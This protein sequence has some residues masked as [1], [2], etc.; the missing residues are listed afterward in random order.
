MLNDH[1]PKSQDTIE[2]YT[3][4][5]GHSH[6]SESFVHEHGTFNAFSFETPTCDQLHSPVFRSTDNRLHFRDLNNSKQSPVTVLS[7][8]TIPD[9]DVSLPR[10]NLFGPKSIMERLGRCSEFSG[11]PQENG[12]KFL[13]EFESYAILHEL[14]R[15]D[16]KRKLAA[17]HLHLKGPALT[18]FDS[19]SD[20]TRES[21]EDVCVLFKGKFV[22]FQAQGAN[23]LMHT[24]IFQSLTLTPG[25][26]VDDFYCSVLEKGQLLDK[27]P[28]E[29]MAKFIGGLPYDMA[30]FVRAGNPDDIQAALTAAK[31]AETCGYRK[32]EL[33]VNAITSTKPKYQTPPT[34]DPYT[35]EIRSLKAQV[36]SLSEIVLGKPEH[37]KTQNTYTNSELA[38]LKDEV[39][40][41]SSAVSKMQVNTQRAGHNTTNDN[42]RVYYKSSQTNQR[43][44]RTIYCYRCNG[45]SHYENEC[46]WNGYGEISQ[47][48]TCQICAQQG[49]TA[50]LCIK[51]SASS[52]GNYR[53]PGDRH[54]RPE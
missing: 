39:H 29:L 34:P 31:M 1:D 36:K 48:S 27:P 46:N 54:D 12:R 17:F 30:Y 14:D 50:D 52:S 40:T 20:E 6:L 24:E 16:Q 25:Q 21:W 22:N 28:H 33:S 13:K 26:S 37:D 8:Q 15:Y 38:E 18:W 42:K 45:A 9:I 49:H 11:Y 43:G 5:Q 4:N 44:R 23:S 2:Q 10:Q 19:L 3:E 41:L 53:R 35:E 7:N 51:R 32:H 47:N